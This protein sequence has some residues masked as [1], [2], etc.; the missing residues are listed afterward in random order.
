MKKKVIIENKKDISG[1][2]IGPKEG[3]EINGKQIVIKEYNTNVD[4]YGRN[5]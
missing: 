5:L 1:K 4:D 3:I 2:P